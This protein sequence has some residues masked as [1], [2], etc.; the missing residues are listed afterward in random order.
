VERKR[1]VGVLGTLVW[2]RIWLHG[3]SSPR[4]GWGGIAYSLAAWSA[5]SPPGWEVVPIVKLGSD[6]EAQADELL[7]ELPH[8]AQGGTRVVPEASNRV[9]L[10]YTDHAHRGERLT[11]GVLP[12]RWEELAPILASL[13]ALYLNFITG[14]EMRLPD[15]ERLR[16]EFGGPI[17]TDLHSLLL[18]HGPDGL[19]CA[20]PLGEWNRWVACFDALQTN[21]SELGTQAQSVG[22][23][24][25]SFAGQSLQCGPALFVV[26]LGA[27]GAGYVISD[28]A[29]SD[30]LSWPAR[31]SSTAGQHSGRVPPPEGPAA[32]DPTGCG[33]VWGSTLFA[34]LL[35]GAEL[36]PA[37]ASAHRAAARKMAHPGVSGL[38]MH[39]AQGSFSA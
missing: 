39:L 21:D 7:A 24:P 34:E 12:W 3:A 26:T 22:R 31:E 32:G 13:D 35:A 1:R 15:A 23:D 25:W 29:A 14:D 19:R 30:P 33:D 17:Y 28:G 6:L 27:D 2:D 9:E 20:R 8:L 18:G 5:A 10:R 36:E 37:M 38:Y 11:G 16:H 4:E